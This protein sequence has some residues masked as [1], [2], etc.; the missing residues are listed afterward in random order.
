MVEWFFFDRIDAKAGAAAIGIEDH[1]TVAVF[2]N[3]AKPLI[4]RAEVAM[5]R[6][7]LAENF[8]RC[9]VETGPPLR[10]DRPIFR[11]DYSPKWCTVGGVSVLFGLW[12][13]HSLIWG[14]GS[15]TT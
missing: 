1:L 8:L 2:S 3:K 15:Q 11:R 9:V 4:A 12:A 10:R 6:A 13:S 14:Y 5:S 7:E